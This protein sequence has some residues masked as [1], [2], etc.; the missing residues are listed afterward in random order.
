MQEA[1]GFETRQPHRTVGTG[2]G[3]PSALLRR[4]ATRPR[5]FESPTYRRRRKGRP[6]S[7]PGARPEREWPRS[8]A[9]GFES[10][11]FRRATIV[12][13][14]DATLPPSRSEF[15]SRSSLHAGATRARTIGMWSSL[16]GRLL[17]EQEVVGSN[18]T[19]PTDGPKELAYRRGLDRACARQANDASFATSFIL[20]PRGGSLADAPVSGTGVPRDV[21]VRVQSRPPSGPK[22]LGY[23]TINGHPQ[24]RTSFAS[25]LPRRGRAWP[26]SQV[27]KTPD[28]R[29]GGRGS[30]P[31][32]AASHA[33]D[34]S[35]DDKSSLVDMTHTPGHAGIV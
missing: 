18:P 26:C 23:R 15:E 12:Q 16:G 30:I 5:G 7:V 19:I 14:Q 13:G 20:R 17:R 4:P 25:T 22:E 1:R 11:P 27:A 10:L 28:S 34:K 21:L 33:C 3:V 6:A 8:V 32:R 35:G 31:R 2:E 9:W 24:L 29:S